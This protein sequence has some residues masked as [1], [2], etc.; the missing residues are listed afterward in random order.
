MEKTPVAEHIAALI[1]SS[2]IVALF[3]VAVATFH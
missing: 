2:M 1:C 3:C